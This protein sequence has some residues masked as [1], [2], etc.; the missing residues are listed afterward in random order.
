MFKSQKTFKEK[1]YFE[2]L[3]DIHIIF[4][5]LSTATHKTFIHVVESYFENVWP[6]D[7]VGQ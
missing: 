7:I 1:I 4:E 6:L 2:S 3:S 5:N